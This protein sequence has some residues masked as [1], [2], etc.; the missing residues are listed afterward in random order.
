ME[1]ERGGVGGGGREREKVKGSEG[2]GWSESLSCLPNLNCFHGQ[3]SDG[4]HFSPGHGWS[5]VLDTVQL[6]K[7][8]S[9]IQLVHEARDQFKGPGAATQRHN[10]VQTLFSPHFRTASPFPSLFGE[11]E[12][13]SRPTR[14]SLALTHGTHAPGQLLRR[15]FWNNKSHV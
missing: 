4:G 12:G 2:R 9:N 10:V 6:L 13:F 11:N 1:R 14:A 5:C 8:E 3:F 7:G 15:S